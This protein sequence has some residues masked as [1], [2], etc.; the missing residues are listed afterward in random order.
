MTELASS[1]PS[2]LFKLVEAGD[3]VWAAVSLGE[4][5]VG[6]A[7]I[8]DLGG[9][10]LVVDTF[11]TARAAVELRAAAKRLT[12]LEAAWVVNTHFHNDHCSGNEVFAEA[13]RIAATEGTRDMIVERAAHLPERIAAAEAQLAEMGPAG[14]GDADAE[15]RRTDLIHGIELARRLKVVAPDATFSD[16]LTL[17]GERRRAEVLAVGAAHTMSDAVVHLPDDHVLISGDVVLTRSHAWVGD[18]DMRNWIRVLERLTGLGA[19]TVIPGHGEVGQALAITEM[20]GYIGDLLGLVEAAVA[21]AP[22]VAPEDLPAPEI[23][24]RYR[25]WGWS[26]GWKDDFPAAVKAASRG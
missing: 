10:A 15:R 2:G 8:V 9:R 25:T 19:A 14:S 7:S 17:S 16:R 5:T 11:I 24:E 20:A 21:A 23:P 3:R 1:S 4:E 6:N 22:G 13:A 26:E 12:G 18:G